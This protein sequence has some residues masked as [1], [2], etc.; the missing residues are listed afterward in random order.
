MV[1]S[2]QYTCEEEIISVKDSEWIHQPPKFDHRNSR[3]QDEQ[4]RGKRS[5]AAPPKGPP[6]YTPLATTRA[7]A[8]MAIEHLN[9]VRWP[10]KM[11]ETTER[12]AS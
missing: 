2:D 4:G 12:I 1:M 9:V 6:G 11:K 7:R 8:L 5:Y 3:E 10:G